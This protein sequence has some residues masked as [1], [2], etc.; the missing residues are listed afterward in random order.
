MT[1]CIDELQTPSLTVKIGLQFK[2]ITLTVKTNTINI[3]KQITTI[4]ALLV[5]FTMSAQLSSL[6]ENAITGQ[7]LTVSNA[8]NHGD[9]G[10]NAVDL[11]Y[12]S[13]VST[14]KGATGDYSTAMGESTTASVY[15][16]TAMG[17]GTNASGYASTAMGVL[18]PPLV[19]FPLQW[20]N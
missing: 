14:T 15:A 12:S 19:I 7:R 2:R 20:G 8:A 16:S 1:Y 10:S 13:S 6:T 9:I 3:M 4:L 11:S 5:S 18:Q 17:S